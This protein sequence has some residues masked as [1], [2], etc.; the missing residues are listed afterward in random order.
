VANN[1]LLRI[2]QAREADLTIAINLK[3]LGSFKSLPPVH[4]ESFLNIIDRADNITAQQVFNA[5]LDRVKDLPFILIQP[6]VVHRHI[7]NFKDLHSVIEAGYEATMK[8]VPE[9][10]LITGKKAPN[11]IKPLYSLD[12]EKCQGCGLCE[13]NCENDLWHLTEKNG[14]TTAKYN[15]KRRNK[16]NGAMTCLRNCPYEAIL[17][18]EE[19]T[20]L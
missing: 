15:A 13:L 7:F 14:K 19:G 9:H 6:D 3:N 17:I 5:N 18:E 2:G 4:Q 10:P 1:L 12:I 11:P 20:P 16:C 8:V